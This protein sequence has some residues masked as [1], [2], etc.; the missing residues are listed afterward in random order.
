MQLGGNA[1]LLQRE[2]KARALFR[3]EPIVIGVH[4]K[5]RRRGREYGQIVGY[6]AVAEDEKVRPVTLTIHYVRRAAE[7]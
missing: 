3:A 7:P 1:G 6:G 2:V 4:E 5:R